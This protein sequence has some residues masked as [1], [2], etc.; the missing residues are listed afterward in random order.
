MKKNW[1]TI[2]ILF[3]LAANL[4]LLLTLLIRNSSI[5]PNLK[6]RI[7]NYKIEHVDSEQGNF[8]MHIAHNLQMDEKQQ[9]QL[10]VF[11]QEF[12]KQKQDLGDKMSETKRKYF[13]ILASSNPDNQLLENLADSLGMLHAAMIKLDHQHYK[14]LKS[15]CTAKQAAQLDSLGRIHMHDRIDDD[16]PD[17]QRRHG[18]SDNNCRNNNQ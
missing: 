16:M 6:H 13:D 12:H 5:A 9:E 17:N 4:A 1:L 10:K 11:S 15:I 3:L 7:Y 14:N 8:E 18:R 2:L